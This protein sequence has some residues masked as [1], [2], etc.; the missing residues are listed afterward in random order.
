MRRVE[1]EAGVYRNGGDGEKVR[2]GYRIG[3]V[4]GFKKREAIVE[5]VVKGHVFDAFRLIV[6]PTWPKKFA[7]PRD[8][9]YGSGN[10]DVQSAIGEGVVTREVMCDAKRVSARII[11]DGGARKDTNGSTYIGRDAGNAETE[12]TEAVPR[13]DTLFFSG[14]SGKRDGSGSIKKW[15]GRKDEAKFFVRQHGK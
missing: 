7:K 15:Q 14:R 1:F 9:S 8:T 12:H 5:M 10:V 2:S 6:A 13:C 11:M 3:A 4:S